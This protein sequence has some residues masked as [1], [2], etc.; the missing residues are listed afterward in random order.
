MPK[1]STSVHKPDPNTCPSEER[2]IQIAQRGGA[3]P[4]ER[5]HLEKCADCTNEGNCLKIS[6]TS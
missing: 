1:L 5:K 3:L 6:H 4:H 2:L